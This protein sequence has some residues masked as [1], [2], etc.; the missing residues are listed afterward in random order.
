MNNLEIISKSINPDG[1]EID[2]LYDDY[3]KYCSQISIDN[4]SLYKEYD[5]ERI[6]FI[7]ND[8]EFSFNQNDYGFNC[9]FLINNSLSQKSDY[10]IGLDNDSLVKTC[11]NASSFI[12]TIFNKYG[13][14][15][16]IIDADCITVHPIMVD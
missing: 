9:E 16:I 11:F 6:S 12:T 1:A 8:S 3:F 5:D 7:S 10:L 2:Y 14:I 13:N 15:S 4:V